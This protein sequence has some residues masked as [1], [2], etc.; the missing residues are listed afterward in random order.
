MQTSEYYDS[1]TPDEWK[2]VLGDHLNYH[3]GYYLQGMSFEEGMQLATRRLL[4]FLSGPHVLDLGCGWGGPALEIA[5]NGYDV[6]CVTNSKLQYEYCKS[7][8]F[9]ARLLDVER[10]EIGRL[11]CFDSVF[12]MES[13]DHVFDKPAL[14]A[15]LVGITPRLVFVTNCSSVD[16]DTPLVTF[17]NTMCMTSVALLFRMLKQAGWQVR[18]AADL[19]RQSMP[20]F[21]FW[22]TRIEAAYP[23]LRKPPVRLLHSLCEVALEDPTAFEE[24]FPLLMVCADPIGCGCSWQAPAFAP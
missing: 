4:P 20:T 17:G 21:S 24:A 13:L 8:E 7:L 5:G 23:A 10:D 16:L 12:M 11:G 6:V 19:R 1:M 2:P 22:K 14:L 3:F 18:F 15:K 9:K